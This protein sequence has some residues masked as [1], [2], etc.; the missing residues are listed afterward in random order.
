[1]QTQ[2]LSMGLSPEVTGVDEVSDGDRPQESERPFESEVDIDDDPDDAARDTGSVES[3]SVDNGDFDNG[4]FNSG[5]F[6]SGDF[7]SGD[8][9]SGD[10]D[11]EDFDSDEMNED[12]AKG[13]ALDISFEDEEALDEILGIQARKSNLRLLQRLVISVPKPRK[14]LTSRALRSTATEISLQALTSSPLRVRSQIP[15]RTADED[16]LIIPIERG[17][18]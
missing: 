18:S 10:F 7:A 8:F 2:I 14:M 16:L 9:D 17:N 6:D 4:D 3:S 1:M 5:D 12:S 13:E 15:L 11:S